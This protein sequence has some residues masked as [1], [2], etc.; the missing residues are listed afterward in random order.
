MEKFVASA[1]LGCVG[2]G[3]VIRGANGNWICGF[4]VNLGK[5]Q[6]LEAELRGLY[7]GL[8]LACDKGISNLLTEMDAAVVVSLV[9]QVGTLSCHPL[10]AL[11][12]SC[13]VLMRHIGNCH[14]AHVYRE[15]NVAADRM[16]NWSFNLDLRVSYLDEGPAWVSSSLENDFLGVVRPRLICTS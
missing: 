4:A 14:L 9:Q 11:V 15:M 13:C 10:A 6:I 3:G 8:H 2:A 1:A 16:A 12:Q 7:F 5:G